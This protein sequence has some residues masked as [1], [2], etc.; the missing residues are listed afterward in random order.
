M[1]PYADLH[2][3]HLEHYLA[4]NIQL[5]FAFYSPSTQ[6]VNVLILYLHDWWTFINQ[7]T[8][9]DPVPRTEPDNKS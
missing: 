5:I 7:L 6:T 9:S 4:H 8:T 2:I 3:Q 1:A